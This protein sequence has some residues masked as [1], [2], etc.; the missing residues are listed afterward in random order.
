MENSLPLHVC[1]VQKSSVIINRSHTLLQFI[2]ITALIYYRVSFLFQSIKT[3]D[4]TPILP[5]LLVFA[6]ELILSFIW[7][8][9]QAYRWRPVSRTVFPERLPEDKDLPAMDVFIFT[10]DPSKEPTVEVMN[11]VISAMALDYPPEKLYVYLSDDGG[12]SVTLNGM[13]EAWRFANWWL[14]FCR[15]Y[16]I[17][18]RCP[19]AYFS[20]E[21][22][23]DDHGDFRS[24]EFIADKEKVKEKYED[25]IKSLMR[26]RQHASIEIS[27]DHPPVVEVINGK[28]SGAGSVDPAEMPLLVYVSREKRASHPHHFKAGA[29]N[30]LLRVSGLIS[31][32]PYILALDCD[33]YCNDPTSA[34]QAMCF[35]L[36]PKISPSLAFVQFPQKFRNISKTDIYGSQLR[37]A[38]MILWPGLDGHVGPVLSGTGFYLKRMALY[39]SSI[40]EDVDLMELKHSFGPS[41]EF[42]KSLGRNHKPNVVNGGELSSVLLQETE[43]VASCAYENHTKWGEKVGF[44]YFSVAEDFFTGFLLHCKGWISVY[45]DPARPSFLGQGT[46]NLN[47]VLVQGTRWGSGLVEVGISRF[48]PL[49]YGPLNMSILESMCYAELAY[50]PLYCLPVWCLATIPQ[51]CLLNGIPLYPKVSN[52]FFTIFSF[53]FLSSQIKHLQEVFFTG[54]SIQIWINEQRIWM[55]KSVTCHF[56]GT[57]D[58]IM[59]KIGMRQASFLPTNKVVDDEQVKQYQMGKFDFRTSAMFLAPLVSFVIINVTSLIVGVARVIVTG[60]WSEM[61]MQVFLSFFIITMSY[62]IIE[63]MFLRKDK[64]RILP[65]VTLLSS[66]FSIIFLTLG[67]LIFLY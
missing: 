45:C 19:E 7:L 66:V 48:S 12:S 21:D 52:S 6:S 26:I 39:G 25:F 31:S 30:V 23:D 37:S 13:R 40:Q 60:S 15:T 29:L 32:S 18:T 28:S 8:L 46:T 49:I 50:F 9:N 3:R 1:H 20:A 35:H 41:N 62:P 38:Y 47:D 56:Y 55:I 17:K 2:A 65:S 42:I 34:R 63:G 14:P 36:D 53:I 5:W 27:G 57:L 51:L 16:G 10:V 59:K 58:A 43:L 33:M 67:S 11:T 4:T 24:T 64:S 22:E 44:M 61:F 54:G